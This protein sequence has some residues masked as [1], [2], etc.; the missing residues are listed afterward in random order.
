MP[1]G[2]CPMPDGVCPMP[3]GVCPWKRGCGRCELLGAKSWSRT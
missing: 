3:D 2:V 1:D